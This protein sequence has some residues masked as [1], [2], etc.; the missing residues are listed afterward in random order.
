[1]I[2]FFGHHGQLLTQMGDQMLMRAL[3]IVVLATGCASSLPGYPRYATST[4]PTP[5]AATA[6]RPVEQV[7]LHLPPASSWQVL[8]WGGAAVDGEFIPSFR[9]PLSASDLA[10]VGAT[11]PPPAGAVLADVRTADLPVRATQFRRIYCGWVWSGRAT[12]DD[13]PCGL[14]SA[15]LARA[16]TTDTVWQL[17]LDLRRRAAAHGARAVIAVRC[18]G[19]ADRLQVWCEGTAII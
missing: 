5:P 15:G 12:D 9:I 6:A 8:T 4:P 17:L 3:L 11:S 2:G 14:R 1:M 7:S 10:A 13:A 18:F 19:T 16:A